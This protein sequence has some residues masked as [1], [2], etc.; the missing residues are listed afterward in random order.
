MTPG[1]FILFDVGERRFAVRS[2]AISELA[3]P[4][5]VHLFPHTTPSVQG[6]LVRRGQ[7][8]P[9][10]DVLPLLAAKQAP[11]RPFYL[12]ARR[13]IGGAGECAAIP[14]TGECQ[15]VN[16]VEQP[17][18]AESPRYV[19]GLLSLPSPQGNGKEFVSVVD[20]EE[21]LCPAM[22]TETA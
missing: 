7:L 15:L 2:D 13:T 3:L 14:V 6:V 8:V 20:L 5:R 18:S 12:I 10:L 22:A 4:G 9:V 16:A 19:T 11:V 1:S 21:L 17:R